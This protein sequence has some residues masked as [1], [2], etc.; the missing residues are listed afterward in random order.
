MPSSDYIISS[1][2]LK[3]TLHHVVVERKADIITKQVERLKAYKEYEDILSVFGDTKKNNYYDVPLMIE[4]NTWRAMTMLDGGNIMANLKFDDNGQPIE[5][6]AGKMAD[7]ICDY[8]KFSLTVEVTMQ[9]G[10]R[11]YEMEVERVS[12]H[13]AKVKK[14]QNKEACCFFIAPKINDSCIAHFYMLHHTNIEYYGENQSL[15]HLSWK[16][17]KKW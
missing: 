5:T 16:C 13:L 9:S 11:Q 3:K 10:Q 8:D 1:E 15:F 2:E 14:E 12:R 6:A 17:L 7:I 4:W